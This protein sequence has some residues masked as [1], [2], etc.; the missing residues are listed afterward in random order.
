MSNKNVSAPS[1]PQGGDLNFTRLV[2]MIMGSTIGAG[3]FTT[4]GDMA[5]NGAHS[6]AVLIGWGIAGIGMLCLTLCFFGLNKV[7][8]T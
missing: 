3:I 5:A 1:A 7:D 8:L 2:A 6:G 4:A